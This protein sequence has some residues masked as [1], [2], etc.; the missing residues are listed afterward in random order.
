MTMRKTIRLMALAAIFAASMASCSSKEASSETE[1]A[2]AASESVIFGE[3]PA[4]HNQMQAE[5]DAIKK[6]TKSATTESQL[7]DLM[8]KSDQL[9][10]KYTTKI[11]DAAKALNGKAI[12]IADGDIKVTEPVTLTYDGLFSKQDITPKFKVSGK[13]EAAA[14]ITPDVKYAQKSFTVYIAGYDKDGNEVFASKIG[15][16]DAADAGGKSTIKAGTPVKFDGLQFGA[17][18]AADYQKATTLKLIAK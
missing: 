17:K 4:L 9:K 2:S 7:T 18:K 14:D 16:I 5:K 8:E 1:A 3:L 6:E 11:E 12:S 15:F 10:E 13:A